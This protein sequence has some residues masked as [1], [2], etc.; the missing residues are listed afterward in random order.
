MN[1]F[2]DNTHI[3][4]HAIAYQEGI[5]DRTQGLDLSQLH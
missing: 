3:R 4:L 2:S 5:A 1:A